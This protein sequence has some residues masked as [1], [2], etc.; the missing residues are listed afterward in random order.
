M[1]RNDNPVALP[2]R[3]CFHQ[4]VF[5]L[6]PGPRIVDSE[7]SANQADSAVGPDARSAA[8]CGPTP[9]IGKRVGAKVFMQ[10]LLCLIVLISNATTEAI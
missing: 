5:H 7:P 8:R 4:V 6:H 2:L 1:A 9:A 10:E 3:T